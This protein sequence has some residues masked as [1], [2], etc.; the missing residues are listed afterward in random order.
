MK[1]LVFVKQVADTEARI[2]ITNNG[3]SLE[4]E[5]KYAL[6]F[7]DEFAIEEALRIKERLKDVEVVVCSYGPKRSIEAL[8]TAIAMGADRAVLIDSKDLDTDDPLITAKILS[9]FAKGDGF[10]MI[11]CGKQAIDDE[12]A[13]IGPMVAEMLHIPHVG[14]VTKIETPEGGEVRVD[15]D[16]EGG[17]QTVKVKLPCLLIVQKGINEPRVPLITGVMK[18]MKANIPVLDPA[19][20]GIDVNSC[21]KEEAK[22]KVVR[23]ESPGGRPPVKFIEGATAEEKAKRLIKVLKEEARVL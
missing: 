5:N 19:T 2:T 4:V 20:Y 18:A 15:R 10:D 6:N 7:F 17:R 16:I 8:R 14:L 3:R 12:N 11:L 1:I 21:T 23:Y 9:G 13:T 22:V